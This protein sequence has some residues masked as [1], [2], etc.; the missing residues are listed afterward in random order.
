MSVSIFLVTFKA[1][2][3]NSAVGGSNTGSTPSSLKNTE[4]HEGDDRHL[5]YTPTV[6]MAP[7]PRSAGPSVNSLADY[8]IDRPTSFID[9][10]WASRPAPETLIDHLDEL[11]PKVDLDQPIIDDSVTS[12]PPSPSPASE[13]QRY[14]MSSSALPILG[15][16]M[17]VVGTLK[18]E[19]EDNAI[20]AENAALKAPRP[21]SVAVRNM[22]RSSG[23][24]GRMKSIREVVRGAHERGKRYAQQAQQQPT[25]S[26]A[27]QTKQDLLRR[28]STKLFGARLIEM[29]PGQGQR[30]VQQQLQM[31]ETPQS[32]WLK[33]QGLCPQSNC[34]KKL[35]II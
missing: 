28:K 25:G 9:E 16:D 17:P 33:R 30:M 21:P 13:I 23:G 18:E 5:T 2:P 8:P 11:F 29:K 19:D 26:N 27:G 20:A 12:P 31:Q 32:Q 4:F 6:A 22:T 24:L 15:D 34:M 1:T 14:N 7:S 3:I 10:D 35:L